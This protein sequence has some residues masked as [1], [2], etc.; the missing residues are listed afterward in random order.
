MSLPLPKIQADQIRA[1]TRSGVMQ[2]GDTVFAISTRWLNSWKAYVGYGQFVKSG[3]VPKPIDNSFLINKG[4]LRKKMVAQTDFEILRKNAWIL[5]F[6]WYGGGPEIPIEVIAHPTTNSPIPLLRLSTFRIHVTDKVTKIKLSIYSKMSV[7]KEKACLEFSLDPETHCIR[8]F[9]QLH[10]TNILDESLSM[11]EQLIV[12]DQDLLLEP[13]QL[14]PSPSAQFI[15]SS[16]NPTQSM[17]PR[18]KTGIMNRITCDFTKSFSHDGNSIKSSQVLIK[19]IAPGICG[20]Q[21][22]GNSCYMNSALQCL[23]HSSIIH[24]F[25]EDLYKKDINENNSLGAKGE[26]ANTFGDFIKQYWSGKQNVL[27]PRDL[28]ASIIKYLPQFKSVTQEDVH[29]FLTIFLD[30]LHEDLKRSSTIT[31]DDNEILKNGNIIVNS[32]GKGNIRR[33]SSAASITLTLPKSENETEIAKQC[34]RHH[35]SINN[36]QIVDEFHGLLQSKMTCPLCNESHIAFDPFS[37]LSL[38]IPKPENAEMTITLIPADPLKPKIIINSIDELPKNYAICD[39]KKS[40]G[41]ITWLEKPQTVKHD[42]LAF[43]II[44]P[45]KYFA[46]MFL[47][48]VSKKQVLIEE[49]PYLMEI[50]SSEASNDEVQET[51]IKYFDSLWTYGAKKMVRMKLDKLKKRILNKNK[52]CN[53]PPSKII[54]NISKR[55]IF[56]KIESNTDFS[57]FR[58][59]RNIVEHKNS[60][61]RSVTLENCFSKFESL[62]KLDEKNKWFCPNCEK[63]VCAGKETNT[64]MVPN[65]LFIHLKRFEQIDG[66]ICK[67]ETN[68]TFPET[69]DMKKYVVGEQ[70]KDD[71]RYQLVAV[72]EHSGTTGSGHYTARAYSKEKESWFAYNDS[73]ARQCSEESVHSPAAYVLLYQKII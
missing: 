35:K 11:W 21:N 5:L 72:S 67:I 10:A 37:S 6:K 44:D 3:M 18:V 4:Q 32:I 25:L 60:P 8:N 54:T 7:L 34:W 19:A 12:D 46:I 48:I 23:V 50:P 47:R 71:L 61:S 38:P 39:F 2:V 31:I 56:L 43:E 27:A 59:K 16:M 53:F 26:I 55:K 57:G 68:V 69:L 64:W 33:Y 30:K 1:A 9:F 62:I 13:I 52:L 41:K 40:S 20:L 14:I 45:T 36:S 24:Y 66:K 49:G 73:T 15:F 29:E 51:C 63:Y 70:K 22:L 17:I 28:R 58:A 42:L 65:S